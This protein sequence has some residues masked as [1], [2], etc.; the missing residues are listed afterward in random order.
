[1]KTLDKKDLK[2][3]KGGRKPSDYDCIRCYGY[4][5]GLPDSQQGGCREAFCWGCDEL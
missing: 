4:C 3:V 1:M 5:D 2:N